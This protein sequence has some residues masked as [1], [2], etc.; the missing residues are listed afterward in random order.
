MR[1]KKSHPH[2]GA[3]VVRYRGPGNGFKIKF[4]DGSLSPETYGTR[5]GAQNMIDG[6]FGKA[7]GIRGKNIKFIPRDIFVLEWREY[8]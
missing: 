5:K 6:N 4:R 7:G 2:Y 1:I 3:K 8:R